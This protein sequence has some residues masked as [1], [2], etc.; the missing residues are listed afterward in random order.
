MK[1]TSVKRS[2]MQAALCSLIIVGSGFALS[3]CTTGAGTSVA[4]EDRLAAAGFTL[5]P[6]NTSKRQAMLK[7]LP[8]NKFVKSVHG[9][10]VTY[11][12]A[13]PVGCNCLYVGSQQ[14]YGQYRKAQQDARIA[15]TNL[16]AAETYSDNLWDWNEWGSDIN[17][18]DG[19]FGPGFDFY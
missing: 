4:K 14:A 6:A 3:A 18:F 11:V 2:L 5:L 7:R 8:P 12:Y 9:N 15:N 17:N 1:T 19:P 13:D 16:W 10:K